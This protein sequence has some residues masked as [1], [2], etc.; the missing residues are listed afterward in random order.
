[1]GDFQR[2]R[3]Y[4]GLKVVLAAYGTPGIMAMESLFG[5]G[6]PSSGIRLLTHKRDSRNAALLDFAAANDIRIMTGEPDTKSVFARIKKFQPDLLF[7]LHYRRR[8]PRAILTLPKLGCINLHPSLLPEYRGCFSVPWALINGERVTGYTYHYMDHSFDTGKIIT[9]KAVR[10]L[11]TDTAFS[12]FHRLI[13]EG[14]KSFEDVLEK[15]L[16]GRARGSAQRGEGSYYPRKLP[17]NG[18]IDRG[19][20]HARID[21]FIRA[22][23]FPPYKGA[24][25]RAGG[26]LHEVRSLQDYRH[27]IRKY[28]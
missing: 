21:R 26:K 27:F 4:P 12:L 11:G 22:M 28:K 3:R 5:L 18:R 20:T 25:L 19:W 15:V 1:M 2:L 6:V 8:I 13:A 9:Q 23:I 16:Q 7:S 14:M 10:I 24:V 17:Y